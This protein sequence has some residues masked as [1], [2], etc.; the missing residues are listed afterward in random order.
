MLDFWPFP[1]E[2]VFFKPVNRRHLILRI[3]QTLLASKGDCGLKMRSFCFAN[4]WFSNCDPPNQNQT[5]SWLKVFQ[6]GTLDVI[7][8][9]IHPFLLDKQ[10]LALLFGKF[11]ESEFHKRRWS[12]CGW[13]KK[14]PNS[15]RVHHCGSGQGTADSLPRWSGITRSDQ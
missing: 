12:V 8:L 3:S 4:T 15:K 14:V 1:N 11:S 5:R 6:Q 13:S 7:S 10:M 2:L 9:K